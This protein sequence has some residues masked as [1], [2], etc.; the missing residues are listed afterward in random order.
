[1]KTFKNNKVLLNYNHLLVLSSL[2]LSANGGST[3]GSSIN[4]VFSS[5]K[6]HPLIGETNSDFSRKSRLSFATSSRDRVSFLSSSAHSKST[7]TSTSTS[8]PIPYDDDD[9]VRVFF[10]YF[11]KFKGD[12]L[13]TT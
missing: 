8:K 4:S 7:T 6:N 1:M 9:D 11:T 2:F 5:T 3:S 10:G 12:S 13:I